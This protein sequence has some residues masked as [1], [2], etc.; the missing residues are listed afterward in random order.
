MACDHSHNLLHA[1]LDGELDATGSA[2]FEQHLVTCRDC[3]TLLAAEEALRRSLQRAALCETA[4]S[5]LREKLITSATAPQQAVSLPWWRIPLFTAASLLLVFLGWQLVS[6]HQNSAKPQTFAFAILDAHLRSL[7]PNHLTDVLSTDQHTVKPW[8]DGR[9]DFIPPVH[10]FTEQGFPLVGGRLDVV[11]GQM[12]AALVYN[13][14]KHI[15]NVFACK[16]GSL[17]GLPESGEQQGFHW[18]S[19]KQGD[20]T[21]FAISDV[22]PAD[23][24]QLRDLILNN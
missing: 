17:P 11:N 24:T 13:R 9:I 4:P 19:W 10:D 15:I 14:R 6:R 2:T 21:L 22:S 5:S 23:L 12:V 7:Q 18:V 8:F 3:S 20:L 1:Y 16:T